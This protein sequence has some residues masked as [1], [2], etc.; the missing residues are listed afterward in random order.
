MPCASF[1]LEIQ[2]QSWSEAE[3]TVRTTGS[4]VVRRPKVPIVQVWAGRMSYS[5]Q[6]HQRAP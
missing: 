2:Q 4:V 1:E 5:L 3:D 6:E